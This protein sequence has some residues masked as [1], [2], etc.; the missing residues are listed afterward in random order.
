M[1]KHTCVCVYTPIYI[2]W[3][4]YIFNSKQYYFNTGQDDIGPIV[5]ITNLNSKLQRQNDNSDLWD[6][7][8][9]NQ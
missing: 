1:H 7:V 3:E 5:Q 8:S 4:V 9:K 6:I 2:T